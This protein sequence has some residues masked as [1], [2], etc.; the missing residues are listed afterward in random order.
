MLG[1]EFLSPLYLIV[2]ALYFL[3]SSIKMFDI[4][5]TQAKNGAWGEDAQQEAQMFPVPSWVVFIFWADWILAVLLFVLNWQ[6]TIVVWIVRFILK[7]IP[8]LE[9]VGNI[10]L[11]PFKPKL[12]PNITPGQLNLAWALIRLHRTPIENKQLYKKEYDNMLFEARAIRG[13]EEDEIALRRSMEYFGASDDEFKYGLSVDISEI[14]SR[15]RSEV[16]S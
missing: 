8:V 16:D 11:S 14:C 4:R 1:I 7:V 9:T 15:R 13:T 6:A 12:P 3:T 2:L 10:V 5:M